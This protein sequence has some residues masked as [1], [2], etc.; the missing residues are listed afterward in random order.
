MLQIPSRPWVSIVKGHCLA[1]V[2]E[3][4]LHMCPVFTRYV[5]DTLIPHV[6]R[7]KA[8]SQVWLCLAQGVFKS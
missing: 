7:V 2:R 4:P 8:E 5:V 1:L 3:I 6:L